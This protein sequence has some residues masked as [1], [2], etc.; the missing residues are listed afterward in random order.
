MTIK[1]IGNTFLSPSAWGQINSNACCWLCVPPKHKTDGLPS[2]LVT[3]FRP[4]KSIVCGRARNVRPSFPL[5]SVYVSPSEIVS[6]VSHSLWDELYYKFCKQSVDVCCCLA[7]L[8]GESRKISVPL[9]VSARVW[10]LTRD[11]TL[12]TSE[13]CTCGPVCDV[14]ACQL[15]CVYLH[16]CV[17]DNCCPHL[18]PASHLLSCLMCV[19]VS[20]SALGY[21]LFLINAAPFL[22]L[23]ACK[24]KEIKLRLAA[25]ICW[26]HYKCV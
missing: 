18:P 26:I 12:R 22:L 16:V 21:F 2:T 5:L 9:C 10:D 14:C 7:T 15:S 1:I 13:V 24:Q 23:S 8:R 11:V 6:S 4:Q 25:A 19:N 17:S 20:W 3:F